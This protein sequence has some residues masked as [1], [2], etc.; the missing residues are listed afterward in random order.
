MV[1]STINSVSYDI[2]CSFFTFH[3]F[4]CGIVRYPDQAIED[5]LDELG[6]DIPTVTSSLAPDIDEVLADD[7]F[8]N[9]AYQQTG[10]VDENTGLYYPD[11]AGNE[12]DGWNDENPNGEWPSGELEDS[13]GVYFG[14][15]EGGGE[16]GNDEVSNGM[17]F[18][19]ETGEM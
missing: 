9:T 3:I 16:G 10:Y 19:E 4:T 13:S 7:E 8:Q 14:N 15:S 18:D 1:G 2:L 12:V 5:T 17:Y 11:E 6:T